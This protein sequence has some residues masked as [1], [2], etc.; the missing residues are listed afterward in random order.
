MNTFAKFCYW[1][2]LAISLAA[3]KGPPLPAS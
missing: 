2:H 3:G 1:I